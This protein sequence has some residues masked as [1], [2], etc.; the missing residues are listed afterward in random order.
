MNSLM[1]RTFDLRMLNEMSLTLPSSPVLSKITYRETNTFRFLPLLRFIAIVVR[2]TQ[3]LKISFFFLSY[4][5]M[6]FI[7]HL[8][9]SGT[10]AARL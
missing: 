5:S 8:K 4:I 7:S 10:T 3:A 9:L 6:F 1:H 2:E